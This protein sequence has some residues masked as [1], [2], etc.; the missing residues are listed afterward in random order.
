[1]ISF[2]VGVIIEI[3]KLCILIPVWMTMMFIQGHSCVIN[4]KL[5]GPF[6]HKFLK[7]FEKKFSQLVCWNPCQVCSTQLIFKGEISVNVI[8]E[9]MPLTL[10]CVGTLVNQFFSNLA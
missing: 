6:S 4:Q 10:A 1:M 5:L 2:K 7:Q 9:N 3:T 8:F